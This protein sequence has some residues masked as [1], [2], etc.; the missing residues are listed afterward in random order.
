MIYEYRVY[1]AVP[2]KLDA[3]QDRFLN[4]TL[5]FFARHG[6]TVTGIYRPVGVENELHYT[7]SFASTEAKDAAWAAFQGDAEWQAVKQQS[8]VG[9][10]LL[11]KQLVTVLSP[12]TAV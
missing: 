3:V 4:H 8:E 1:R 5:R 11:E 12:V 7:T 10:P 6:I 9:G 2:G